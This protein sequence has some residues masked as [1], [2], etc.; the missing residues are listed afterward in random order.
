MDPPRAPVPPLVA[1]R[2]PVAA[3]LPPVAAPPVPVE[4]PGSADASTEPSRSAANWF[5]AVCW[6]LSLHPLTATRA[7]AAAPRMDL[8]NIHSFCAILSDVASERHV[9][10]SAPEARVTL[11][12][13]FAPVLRC[14][15]ARRTAS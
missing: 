2:P 5:A 13:N 11:L 6:S 4:P 8:R 9:L 12:A 1:L 14:A 7:S 10:A 3:L 15:E